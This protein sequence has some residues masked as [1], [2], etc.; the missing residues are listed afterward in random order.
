MTRRSVLCASFSLAVLFAANATARS[1]NGFSLDSASIPANEIQRGGPPRDGIPALDHP[2]TVSAADA[3]WYDRSL[4]VGVE[5]S[6]Q[7]RAY[8]IAILNWHELVNDRLGGQPILV[9]FCP[10]CGTA[11]VFDRR[12]EGRALRFGVSGL[13]FQSDLLMFDRSSESLWSQISAE[14]VSG[15]RLGQQLRLLRAQTTTWGEWRSRHPD[16]TV[17]S[18]E[19]GHKRNYRQTPYKGYAKSKRLHFPAPTDRRYHPKSRVVGLRLADG[20]AR[21]YPA[22]EIKKAGGLV[23]EKFAGHEVRIEVRGSGDIFDV[24][25]PDAVDVIEGFWFAW[26]AFHPESTVYRAEE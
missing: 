13:L 24:D 26:M 17:L 15:P 18:R 7:A 21:A 9:S 4:V 5:L 8:P 19:T 11:M 3:S 23:A 10:L 25:A 6:G 16:S 22:A 14:A 1:L 2:A 12:A 20:S